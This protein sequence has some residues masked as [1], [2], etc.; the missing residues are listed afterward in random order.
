[1]RPVVVVSLEE[2]IPS[3]TSN[4]FDP[5]GQRR[6]KAKCISAFAAIAD[7]PEQPFSL[8]IGNGFVFADIL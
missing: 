4:S 7:R 2:A 5:V 8:R 6:Q 1:L 3:G